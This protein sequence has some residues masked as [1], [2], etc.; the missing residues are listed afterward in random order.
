MII[1]RRNVLLIF[2]ILAL[3]CIIEPV[4]A[5]AFG[6][7]GPLQFGNA[8]E[9]YC[10]QHG[11][12]ARDG[13]CYFLDG[14]YCNIWSF[15]NG[16]CPGRAYYEEMLWQQEAYQWL[17]GDYYS[18]YQSMYYNDYYPP[19]SPGYAGYG[20]PYPSPYANGFY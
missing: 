17:N 8:A 14:S 5:Q 15:F 10:V 13:Y 2:S 12:F 4:W 19:Y 18:P 9:A 16:T 3:G 1:R 11:G 20:Q 7:S 6:S